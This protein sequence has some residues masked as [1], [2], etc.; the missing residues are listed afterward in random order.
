MPD[1]TRRDFLNGAVWLGASSLGWPLAALAAALDDA[2]PG[3]AYPPAL[4]GLRGAHPGAF[5][6]AHALAWSGER[7]FGPLAAPAEQYDLIVIGA[8]ISGLAAAHFYRNEVQ[9]DARIL[10]L[11]NHDDF[12]GHAKRNEFTL[13]GQRYLS[14]GGTQSFDGPSGYSK[15]AMGLLRTLG[16][17]MARLAAAYDRNFFARHQLSLGVFYDAAGFGKA[18]LQR[19]GFPTQTPVADYSR[20]Y[21]PGLALAPEFAEALAK[22]PLSEAQ[23]AKLREVLAAP[24]KAAAYFKGAQGRQ[25]YFGQNYVQY[26]KAVYQIDSPALI[27]LLSMPL[28]EDSALGGTGI[29]LPMAVA[30]GLLGL[31]PAAYFAQWQDK[32]EAEGKDDD[33]DDSKEYVYHFPDGNATLARLL[34]QRLIPGVASFKTPEQCLTARF[35]YGQLDRAGQA[36]RLRLNSLAIH[37]DNAGDGTVV[38]YLRQG[39]L[40][41]ARARRTVMAGWHMMAAHIIPSL[42]ASQKAAMRA[43]IKMPLVYAQV[44]LRQWQPLKQS[45]VGASYC[46]ASYFQFVQMDFPVSLGDY[47]PRREPDA[48]LVLLM[49]RMPCPMLGEGE[50]ADLL[51]QGRADLLGTTFET[52][53]ARIREQLQAMYGPYGFNDKRDIAAITVNRWPHGYV[54]DEAEYKGQPAHSLARKR[55]GRIAIANA[56]AAGKAYTDAAIDMA[57]RAVQELKQSH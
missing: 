27:A 50:P 51:R 23:R 28:A 31:P 3:N 20:H 52:F 33:E 30:G 42:P 15:V 9:R 5:E 45:G 38:R 55:H 47:R 16:I 57:W 53:E 17:D 24:P 49:I 4:T 32:E 8:G 2:A 7:N 36:V 14:Y 21:V 11:D 34:V 12:G 37:A 35:D 46:P 19:S 56:D 39:K 43:N 40:Y 22:A 54:F 26:L 1:I 10:I 44:V 29:S 13:D 41:E 18:V 25:R 6:A 48:P